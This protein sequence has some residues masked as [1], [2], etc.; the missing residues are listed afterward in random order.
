MTGVCLALISACEAPVERRVQY[1]PR[2]EQ[3]TMDLFLPGDD[4]TGRPG[5]LMVHRG[6]W[7]KFDSDQYTV[8]R[9]P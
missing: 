1:D 6:G 7:R 9:T 4:Y 3:T 2:F 8:T 5:I